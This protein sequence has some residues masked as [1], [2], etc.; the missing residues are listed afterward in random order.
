MLSFLGGGGGGLLQGGSDDAKAA[1]HHQ[2]PPHVEDP[3]PPAAAGGLARNASNALAFQLALQGATLSAP[4]GAL[5]V[6]DCLFSRWDG[7]PE[8]AGAAPAPAPRAPPL[9]IRADGGQPPA[10]GAAAIAAAAAAAEAAHPALPWWGRAADQGLAHALV[11]LAEAHAGLGAAAAAAALPRNE[12]L[13]WLLLSRVAALDY[14]G[15][16]P[17]FFT[18]AR[19]LASW[20]LRAAAA[21]ER[22]HFL[23]DVAGCALSWPPPLSAEHR[24][25]RQRLAG[26]DHEAGDD[27]DDDDDDEFD[28]DG[29]RRGKDA[30]DDDGDEDGRTDEPEPTF[31]VG[32]WP[33]DH[34]ARTMC[35]V[36]ARATLWSVAA[37]AAAIAVV[38]A[39]ASAVTTL[40]HRRCC[41]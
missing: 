5:L 36:A 27:D 11:S 37:A 4:L 17:V 13:A 33:L 25:R 6:G 24:R 32:P 38:V 26:T 35:T 30:G 14:L 28:K 8:C 2:P 31:L 12:T 34:E 15:A 20:L 10:A 21:G 19:L 40:P 16:W 7:V 22:A 39:A 3:A 41:C 23:A 29:G 18:R 1:Q 9:V